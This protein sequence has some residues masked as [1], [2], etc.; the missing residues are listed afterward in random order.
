MRESTKNTYNVLL[1]QFNVSSSSGDKDIGTCLLCRE[2]S[3][4]LS[5]DGGPCE[6]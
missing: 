6:E 1:L 3:F 4:T 2:F 5:T